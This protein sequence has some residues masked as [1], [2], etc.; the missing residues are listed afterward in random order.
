M[1]GSLI[2]MYALV[3]VIGLMNVASATNENF[4]VGACVVMPNGGDVE[5]GEIGWGVQGV[6]PLSQAVDVELSFSKFGDSLDITEMSISQFAATLRWN[7]S[8]SDRTSVYAGAGLNY[9]QLTAEI[10]D[11]DVKVQME[12]VVG[13]HGTV[14]LKALVWKGMVLFLDYRFTKLET[15]ATVS[16]YGQTE[17]VD[18]TYDHGLAR[19]GLNIT[20]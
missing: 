20:F 8:L 17:V 9:N 13:Y 4:Q 7:Y 12:N 3:M 5:N 15:T 18:G 2:M 10:E 1:K 16:G 19:V 11:S 6:V 14:G